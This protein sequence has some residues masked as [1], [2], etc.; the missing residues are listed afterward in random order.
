M[1]TIQVI[2]NFLS[3]DECDNV[4]DYCHHAGYSYGETDSPDDEPTG[5]IHEIDK[6]SEIYEL[7]HTE[8]QKLVPELNIVRMYVNCFAPS[9]NPHFHIDGT[10]GVTFLYYAVDEWNIEHGGETQFL[11][12]EEIRGVLP[13]PNRLVW[14]DANIL[15]RATTFRDRHRFTLAVKYSI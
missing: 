14:F 12:D 7:F 13:F 1:A 3:F 6:T 2:D 9:E 11:V 10:S 4:I 5:M 15:H 8:T